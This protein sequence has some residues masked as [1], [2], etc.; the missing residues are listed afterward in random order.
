MEN[1][2]R[3]YPACKSHYGWK[4]ESAI[5]LE[6][7]YEIRIITLKRF[8]GKLVTTANRVEVAEDGH[9]HSYVM[10]GDFNESVISESPARVTEKTVNDQHGRALEQIDAIKARCAA[11]YAAKLSESL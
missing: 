5:P 6:G 11:F 8:G 2:V 1:A 4:A 9:S 7:R 3:T 10:F